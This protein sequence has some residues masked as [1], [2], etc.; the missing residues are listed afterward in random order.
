MQSVTNRKHFTK[1]SY[2]YCIGVATK[3]YANAT[4]KIS[5][6][7]YLEL[8]VMVNTCCK[9]AHKKQ[10]DLAKG[11]NI[12]PNHLSSKLHGVRTITSRDI[13]IIILT[14]AEWCNLSLN[15]VSR[16]LT[17]SSLP[18]T[19]FSPAEWSALRL[20]YISEANTLRDDAA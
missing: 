13:K 7:N 6:G 15:D 12:S 10:K 4:L 5:P 20:Q 3:M 16:I 8:Q 17:I 19:I 11:L 14:L 2:F 9:R 1:I 18:L